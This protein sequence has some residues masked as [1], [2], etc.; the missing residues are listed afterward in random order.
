MKL[1]KR[2]KRKIRDMVRYETNKSLGSYFR[3]LYRQLHGS[4]KGFKK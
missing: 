1:T 4:M 3:G 2:Q